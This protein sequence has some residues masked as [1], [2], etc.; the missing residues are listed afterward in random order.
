MRRFPA[1]LI[2]VLATA[3]SAAVA[4]GVAVAATGSR[5]GGDARLHRGTSSFFPVPCGFSHRNQDDPIVFPGQRGRSHDH[6]Y[7]GNAST[8]ASSTPASLRAAER[9]S[10]LIRRDTAAYWAP[11]LFVGGK[12]VEP[13]GAIVYY[14]RRTSDAVDPFPAGLKMIAGNAEA[15]SPQGEQVTFWSC[16][17]RG[18][19]RSSTIP[20]CNGFPGL[21]L[22]VN[23][24]SCWDGSRLDSANHK[25]HMAYST[26]GSCPGSH[27]VEVP[28]LT[29]VI[30]YGV[31]GGSGS[32][33][34]SGGQ[35][36]GHADFVNAWDQR[37]LAALVDRYLNRVGG[38][39]GFRD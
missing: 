1:L 6:T 21:R 33:L 8:N 11:T 15:R 7:F 14:V 24:P 34:S 13:L 31:A 32:E 18:A 5:A 22:H 3:A 17:G 35:F 9:T 12:A 29:I 16:G 10:C 25:S 39:R 30:Y 4:V 27:P 38:F 20:T 37:T 28:G 2:L 23:F 26:D 19:E 36:S